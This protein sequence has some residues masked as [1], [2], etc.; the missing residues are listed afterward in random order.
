MQAVR[1]KHGLKIMMDIA[2]EGNKYMQVRGMARSTGAAVHR[3]PAWRP[4]AGTRVGPPA[5]LRCAPGRALQDCKP[6]DLSKTEPARCATVINVMVHLVR[7]L[8]NIAEPFMPGFTDKVSCLAEG[9]AGRCSGVR[10]AS[11]AQRAE[12]CP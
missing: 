11:H 4:S 1:M 8:A 10:C 9:W 12:R 5:S 2:G 6:W 3:L 7:L